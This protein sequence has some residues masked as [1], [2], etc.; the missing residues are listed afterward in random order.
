MTL[1][2]SDIDLPESEAIITTILDDAR[3]LG[4][5]IE[6]LRETR[7]LRKL[8]DESTVISQTWRNYRELE[9]L[10]AQAR[11]HLEEITA[12]DETD[13]EHGE[14]VTVAEAGSAEE[15]ES[16]PVEI[17]GDAFTAT[18]TSTRDSEAEPSQAPVHTPTPAAMVGTAPPKKPRPPRFSATMTMSPG[19]EQ[20]VVKHQISTV[21]LEEVINDPTTSWLGEN[22][23]SPDKPTVAVRED[24]EW[25]VIYYLIGEQVKF[26]HVISVK[27]RE[28]LYK[29]R[30][31]LTSGF[32]KAGAGTSDDRERR[33]AIDSLDTFV[34]RAEEAGLEYTP[35]KKHGKISKPGHLPTVTIPNTPS[36]GRSWNNAVS[37]VKRLLDVEL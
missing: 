23:M 15:S 29:E 7:T 35:G 36:D 17:I 30:R 10:L 19:A 22:P 21:G 24:H 8:T 37:T 6:R 11:S 9:D 5:V 16:D 13:P 31:G 18:L 27:P 14:D 20:M 3:K 34:K 2:P 26:P 28:V 1:E 25:G 12:A 32:R 4:T 33:P